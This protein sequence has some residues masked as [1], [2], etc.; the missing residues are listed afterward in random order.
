MSK[1]LVRGNQQRLR[2]GKKTKMKTWRRGKKKINRWAEIS[3]PGK[4]KKE[5]GIETPYTGT[6]AKSKEY[7]KM[8]RC[9][10]QLM[11]VFNGGFSVVQ[12]LGTTVAERN[13]YENKGRGKKGKSQT[14]RGDQRT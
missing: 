12:G 3:C 10:S 13:G 9:E 4:E 14:R 11:K 8:A 1:T 2:N 7:G 6:C 5:S